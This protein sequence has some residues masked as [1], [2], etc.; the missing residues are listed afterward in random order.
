MY[1]KSGNGGTPGSGG[2]GAGG[3]VGYHGG[4]GE[5]SECHTPRGSASARV[6]RDLERER[7][8]AVTVDG[9]A[10]ARG[11]G[12]GGSLDEAVNGGE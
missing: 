5:T 1:R 2:N 8:S 10:V 7:A 12:G 3:S 9:G 6:R 11:G 4:G